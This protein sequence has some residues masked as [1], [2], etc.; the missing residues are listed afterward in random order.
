M[1]DRKFDYS[2]FAK[3]SL[4]I[5][6]FLC[7]ALA[8]YTLIFT[9]TDSTIYTFTYKE[10]KQMYVDSSELTLEFANYPS[11]DFPGCN[12]KAHAKVYLDP[13]YTDI[14][15]EGIDLLS[16][17]PNKAGFKIKTNSISYREKREE[18]VYDKGAY[19]VPQGD[20][21]FR[22]D[23]RNDK[24]VI[25]VDGESKT[26]ESLSYEGFYCQ[27]HSAEAEQIWLEEVDAVFKNIGYYIF[28]YGFWISFAAMPVAVLL[29]SVAFGIY[30]S[31]FYLKEKKK[32]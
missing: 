12:E 13:L 32:R 7:I 21:S 23:V 8:I 30:A 11:C 18:T 20:G 10:A 14:V 17:I 28:N 5:G 19:L 4:G 16:T 26:L 1:N 24:Y 22:I 2:D 6:I 3:V 27:A 9:V 15:P 25:E 29:G 31:V